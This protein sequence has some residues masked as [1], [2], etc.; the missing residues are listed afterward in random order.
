[1]RKIEI[2]MSGLILLMVATALYFYFSPL[3]PAIMASHWNMTGQADGF[4][5][6]TFSL[7]LFPVIA[8][9]LSAILLFLPRLDPKKEN[10]RQF[11]HAYHRF[12]LVFLLFLF[13][14][15]ILVL[16]WNLQWVFSFN[17][18]LAAGLA[19]FFYEIGK[20]LGQTKMNYTIGIRTPWTL[21]SEEVWNKT[22]AM[23]SRWTV[24][25]ACIL[26]MGVLLPQ[27]FYFTLMI[28]LIA[29]VGMSFGVSYWVYRKTKENHPNQ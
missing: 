17:Q 15:F 4:S 21:Y 16:L 10:I 19:W 29:F 28:F 24:Y 1:M 27:Y 8:I 6:K 5:S 23:V 25:F 12:I 7:F 22:H 11:E 9:V 14:L 26:L 2:Q 18:A 20:L 13:Y 3:M